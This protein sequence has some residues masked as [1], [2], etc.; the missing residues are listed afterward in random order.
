MYRRHLIAAAALLP[1]RRAWAQRVCRV[2]LLTPGPAQTADTPLGKSLLAGLAKAGY[3]PGKNLV[4]E[5]RGA[6]G[7]IGRLPA[8]VQ[9]LE[10]A[11]VDVIVT[12]SYPSAVAA[13]EHTKLPVVSMNCGD[14]VGTGLVASLAH[15]GGHVTGVSDVSAELTPKRMDLL[16]AVSPGLSRIGILWNDADNGMQLRA[17]ASE[18]GARSMALDVEK[19]AVRGPAD[20][21]AAF[22]AM[23]GEKPG[24]LL[25][26]AD[27]LTM[28]NT[29][30]ITEFAL[31]HKLPVIFESD[32]LAAMG[33]LMA[34]GPDQDE[35]CERVAALVERIVKGTSPAD[36]PFEQP[37]R[38][39]LVVNL[40]TARALGITVPP[41][42]LAAADEVIE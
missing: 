17:K 30:R 38:F 16:K 19:V 40:K 20:F 14:P 27:M 25:V 12:S 13:K 35:T 10:A 42:V 23:A 21:D 11:K 34:Y 5:V 2:G 1:L 18:A 32:F 26:V 6:Q 24:G 4:L 31:A 22:G 15:P 29:K 28:A 8:L 41:I 33:G 37:T 3:L 7:N 9:E 36:L 39:K